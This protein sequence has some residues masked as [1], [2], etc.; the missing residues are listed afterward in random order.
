MAN[1]LLD[2]I[3]KNNKATEPKKVIKSILKNCN[4]NLREIFDINSHEFSIFPID[5]RMEIL[6]YIMSFYK[7]NEDRN[8]TITKKQQTIGIVLDLIIYDWIEVSKK[9]LTDLGVND[10]ALHIAEYLLIYKE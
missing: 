2:E 8:I 1:E 9:E 7:T 6:K 4:T 3:K 5:E 10:L